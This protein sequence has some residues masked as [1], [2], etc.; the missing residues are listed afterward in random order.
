LKSPQEKLSQILKNDERLKA[1][2]FLNKDQGKS[3]P[4]S[5]LAHKG[6]LQLLLQ[7]VGLEV[8]GVVFVPLGTLPS[9]PFPFA[10]SVRTGLLAILESWMRHKPAP[11]DPARAFLPTPVLLHG[12]VPPI[13]FM[14]NHREQDTGIMP[15]LVKVW[16]GTPNRGETS[17]CRNQTPDRSRGITTER[18]EKK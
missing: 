2:H 6:R 1:D 7:I 15:Q 5:A 3:W 17:I 16:I 4:E 12:S 9:V 11:T 10:L 13:P 14:R 18:N 8:I